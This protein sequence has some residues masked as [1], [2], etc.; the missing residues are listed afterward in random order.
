MALK[1]VFSTHS[2]CTYLSLEKNLIN[3]K[4]SKI[5]YLVCIFKAKQ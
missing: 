1:L 5:P 4:P 2:R 3:W